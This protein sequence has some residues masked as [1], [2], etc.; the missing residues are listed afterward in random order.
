MRLHF[1][2]IYRC[3][4]CYEVFILLFPLGYVF[5]RLVL[6]RQAVA[7]Y[8]LEVSEHQSNHANER[9]QEVLNESVS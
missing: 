2:N 6:A 9:I 4:T 1:H 3:E 7:E 5:T 8:D